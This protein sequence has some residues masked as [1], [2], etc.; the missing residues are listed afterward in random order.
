MSVL[1]ANAYSCPAVA[2][3]VPGL[4]VAVRPGVTGLLA[5]DVPSFRRAVAL[6]LQDE[7]LRQEYAAAAR[8]WAKSFDW[9]VSAAA[10]LRLLAAGAVIPKGSALDADD[11]GTF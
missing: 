5:V 10:T 3:D 1:E 8:L 7:P 2:F 11:V 4:R 9:D 6:L